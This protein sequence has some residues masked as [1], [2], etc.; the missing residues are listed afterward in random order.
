MTGASTGTWHW[1]SSWHP[2]RTAASQTR[3]RVA[4]ARTVHSGGARRATGSASTESILATELRV[5]KDTAAVQQR[6]LE[7]R[8]DEM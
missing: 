6:E 4:P 7:L 2:Q 5:P 3:P 8:P 1:H